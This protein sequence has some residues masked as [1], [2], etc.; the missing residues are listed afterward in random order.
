MMK[1]ECKPCNRTDQQASEGEG[2]G[3]WTT[4]HEFQAGGGEQR[5]SSHT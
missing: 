3:G 1:L 5:L 4:R 2:R